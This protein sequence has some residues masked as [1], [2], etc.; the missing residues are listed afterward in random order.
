MP[1]EDKMLVGRVGEQASSKRHGGPASLGKVALA[2][3]TEESLIRG[4]RLP[5]R[6][7]RRARFAK[8]MVAAELESRHLVDWQPVIPAFLDLEV[9]DWKAVRP[10]QF[11]A[12]RLQPCQD[13]AFGESDLLQRGGK[14]THPCPS[15][16]HEAL[17]LIS[18]LV[19]HDDH[20]VIIGACLPAEHPLAR[21]NLGSLGLCGANMGHDG[22]FARDQSALRL[23][24]R[25]VGGRKPVARKAG[26]DL[27]AGQNFMRQLVELRGGECSLE[28]SVVLVRGVNGTRDDEKLLAGRSLD[29]AP[30]L[31]RPA[32][33]RHVGRILV[34]RQAD[35]TADAMR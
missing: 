11:G 6:L 16:E 34:I 32:K 35:N 21:M 19:G 26:V 5:P 27:G 3:G 25:A 9:E 15:S 18:A 13:L 28:Q 10:E 7:V 8:M 12:P 22:A 17:G 14:L 31:V 20:A 2:K 24:N 1:V 30:K 33:Q 23:E 4:V 29:L